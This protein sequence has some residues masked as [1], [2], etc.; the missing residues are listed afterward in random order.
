MTQLPCFDHR[1]NLINATP[2]RVP[3]L[4]ATN[5]YNITENKE[6]VCH[7]VLH[8]Q[9]GNSSMVLLKHTFVSANNKNK[10]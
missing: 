2:S 3:S 10:D 6:K 9:L 5:N 4:F 1:V 7:V 8:K